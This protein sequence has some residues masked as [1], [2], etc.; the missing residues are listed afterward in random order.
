MRNLLLLLFAV[1]LFL[2][3][4]LVK[5]DCVAGN[6]TVQNVTVTTVTSQQ[7]QIEAFLANYI[8]NFIGVQVT[9]SITS[10]V[11]TPPA[12]ITATLEIGSATTTLTTAQAGQI[13]SAL[14]NPFA[15]FLLTNAFR[16]PSTGLTGF[17]NSTVTALNGQILTGVCPSS[18]PVPTLSQWGLIILGL[19]LLNVGAV[20]LMRRRKELVPVPVSSRN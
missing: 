7:A 3:P 8:S 2:T 5:A 19:F 6:I 15:K 13:T 17:S 11:A 9:V 16:S 12:G 18:L 10:V 14:N 1:G 4:S 20:A